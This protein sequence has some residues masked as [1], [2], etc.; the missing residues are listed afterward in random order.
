M[1]DFI[2]KYG[3]LDPKDPRGRRPYGMAGKRPKEPEADDSDLELGDL[4][5]PDSRIPENQSPTDRMFD[6]MKKTRRG[7]GTPY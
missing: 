7:H 1:V 2:K 5:Q 3:Y 4:M 6:L